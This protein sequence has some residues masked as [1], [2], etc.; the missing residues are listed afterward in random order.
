[1]FEFS[2]SK[3]L[4]LNNNDKR[5]SLTY[6]LTL[7][8]KELKIS[9]EQGRVATTSNL[10]TTLNILFSVVTTQGACHM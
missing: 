8:I 1:M 4:K 10:I 2:V 3:D 7:I 6:F 9:V 5:R